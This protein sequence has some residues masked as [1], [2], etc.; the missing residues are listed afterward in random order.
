MFKI[1]TYI[2]VVVLLFS[3]Q[4]LV[5]QQKSTVSG[6]VRDEGGE[7]LIGANV[8]INTAGAGTVT[9][10]Y[11]F[12]SLTL[13]EGEYDLKVS[14]VGYE[15]AAEKVALNE[16]IR[17]DFSLEPTSEFIEEVEITAERK[18]ANV[19]NV[20]MSKT[21]LPMK[22][23][24]KIPVLMGETDIIKTIQ[25]LPGVQMVGEGNSGFFVR[26][27]A[28][29][30]NLILLDEAV[31]YNPS[32]IGGFFSVFN[33]D[34]IKNVELYKGGIPAKYGGRL[35]SVLDIRMNEGSN[36]KFGAVGGIGAISSRATFEG[37]LF[38]DKA[39]FIV[40]GRRTYID[41]FFPLFN[42]PA[43]DE[44]SAYFYDLNGKV[45]YRI[46]ENNRIFLS[47]YSGR[48]YA[49]FSEFFQ[50]D[51][52]NITGTMRWNHV[53]SNKLFANYSIIF[54]NYD[55]SL[56]TPE[57]AFAFDW[58]ANVIDKS[59]KNDYTWFVNPQNTIKFGFQA[60]YHTI[61]PGYAN[62]MEGSVF[63]PQSLPH[64]YGLE[65]GIFV[66]N[67]Q[68]LTT[69]ITFQYGLRFSSFHNIGKG[70][71]YNFNENYQVVDSTVH[72]SG[73][74]F[75]D[76]SGFEPR[77]GIRYSVGTNNSIKASY[78][79]TYQYIHL[80]TNTT[81][82]TPID[83]WFMSNPNI[84][85]QH[86]DQVAAGYFHN[87]GNNAVEVSAEVYYKKMYDAVDF[88]DHAS[89]LLNE[90]FDGEL[91]RGS[92]YSY[93]LELYARKQEGKFTGWIS[94]T[95]SKTRRK[96]QGINDGKEYPTPYDRPHDLKIVG[97]YDVTERLNI[98]ANW[99][100]ATAM[101]Y[102]VAVGWGKHENLWHPVFSDRNAVRLPGT[103]YHRLD[104]SVTW[105][106]KSF[107]RFES[108][109]T[110]SAYNAYNRHNLYSIV[111]EEREEGGGPPVM[112][113]MYLFGIIPT[114]TWNFKF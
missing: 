96:I 62:P 76:Y 51:Y 88:K 31:V 23:I 11:G 14:Y 26:G 55:Y 49:K 18:D 3:L 46:N 83:V 25:L 56:G 21:K 92:A 32:H 1:T 48:D 100:Y 104:A 98:S 37:P 84:K 8:Y 80:A 73:S 67:E 112:N 113:K 94:Y 2:G 77:L 41:L 70:T 19:R 63:V 86:A 54:S 4:K 99:V 60:I 28:V 75:H 95:L 103:D 36:Q 105:K 10:V 9:N 43:L 5:A 58:N 114:I 107:K 15:G 71:I 42:E 20:E 39:S 79:R 59:F 47:A 61:K 109:W 16:D 78:N 85:P 64:T 52:G 69:D 102:T 35:S 24:K 65:N 81:T 34:A 93:G 12:Y 45:N 87:F 22:T 40:S 17:V 82:S 7:E 111:Y 74:F 108:S 101:P 89:L 106:N 110:L 38:T 27:G 90:H 6:Y 29:D 33:G 44:T 97:S 30:Q 72:S 53:F 13:P 68:D 57:G 91:R 50:M 66:E